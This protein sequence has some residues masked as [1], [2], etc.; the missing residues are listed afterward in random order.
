MKLSLVEVL[1]IFSLCCLNSVLWVFQVCASLLRGSLKHLSVLNMSKTVFSHRSH[2]Q[3]TYPILSQTTTYFRLLGIVFLRA[4]PTLNKCHCYL[5]STVL[6]LSYVSLH[7][8]T[9]SVKK[10]L[11]PL[12]SSSAALRLWAQ[13]VCRE[14]NC[15]WTLWSKKI[16]TEA[17]F[18]REWLYQLTSCS[19]SQTVFC[20]LFYCLV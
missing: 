7:L 5:N 18:H 3:L 2:I 16:P 11:R 6:I 12:S 14:P 1:C 19:L 13:S 8:H 10:S 4:S 20:F 17:W 9:G 15:R